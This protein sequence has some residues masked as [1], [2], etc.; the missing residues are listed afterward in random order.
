M[1]ALAWPKSGRW[2]PIITPLRPT[3][4]MVLRG[5]RVKNTVLG[6]REVREGKRCAKGLRYLVAADF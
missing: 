4:R 2:S 3:R 5:L 1:I 6:S